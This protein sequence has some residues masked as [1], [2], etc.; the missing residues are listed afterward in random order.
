ME[1]HDHQLQPPPPPQDLQFLSPMRDLIF[2]S[3]PALFLKSAV[4]LKIPDIIAT[5]GPESSYTLSLRQIAA[6]LPS[7]TPHLDY[8]SRIVRYL[9]TQGIFIESQ[10]TSTDNP[11]DFRYGLTD[12]AKM[13][14]VSEGDNNENPFS[15]VPFFLMINHETFLNPLHHIHECVL[16]GPGLSGGAFQIAHGKDLWAYTRENQ[17]SKAVFNT[18]MESF[19]NVT[20][21]LFVGCY[22][23]FEA[24]EKL[25]VVDVGG[26]NGVAI[27]Q[28]VEAHPHIHGINFDLPQ[29]IESA[30]SIPGVEHVAGDMFQSIPS[31]DVVFIKHVLHNWD[32]DRCVKILENCR[33]ALPDNGRL[34]V[35]EAVLSDQPCLTQE[36][37]MIF[38]L[39]M[40]SYTGGG[41][42]RN[43]QQWRSLLQKS[44]FTTLKIATLPG[45]TALN[46]LETTKAKSL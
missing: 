6:R 29:V 41:R 44:G 3:I 35:V 7:E 33:K 43:E 39:I 2:S 13:F 22:Q 28:I 25:R 24:G 40:I 1:D 15:L 30:Q 9:S 4:L 27:A 34:I 46:I 32:D 20:M 31:A 8:L 11:F 45:I 14:F 21:K 42:E 37:K 10:T 17:H 5:A 23:G 36:V 12:T 19:T 26:G 18:G 38:D 16:Q